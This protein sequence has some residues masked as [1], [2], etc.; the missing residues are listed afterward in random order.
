MKS[1]SRSA[2]DV[3]YDVMCFFEL[4]CAYS[5]KNA[6]V[7]RFDWAK[8]HD[9]IGGIREKRKDF[10]VEVQKSGI[11]AIQNWHKEILNSCLCD[12]SNGFLEGINNKTKLMKRAAYGYERFE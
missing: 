10:Y 6:S 9:N 5:L 7:E 11:P 2:H 4:K 12:D 8:T 1:S 3:E